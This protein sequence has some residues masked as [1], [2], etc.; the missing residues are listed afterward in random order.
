MYHRLASPTIAAPVLWLLSDGDRGQPEWPAGA[1]SAARAVDYAEANGL[2]AVVYR[3]LSAANVRVP[4]E[5]LRRLHAVHADD[6]S[7]ATTAEAWIRRVDSALVYAGVPAVWLKGAAWGNALYAQAGPRPMR[8]L[9]FIVSPGHVD[10]AIDVLGRLG[11]E[12]ER[13]ASPAPQHLPRFR[14][15]HDGIRI[16]LHHRLLPRRIYGF[17]VTEPPLDMVRHRRV[18]PDAS[19]DELLFHILHMYLH[20]F[21]HSFYNL[22][23]LHLHDIHLAGAKWEIEPNIVRTS[24]HR[25]MPP[26]LADCIQGLVL[27]LFG[28]SATGVPVSQRLVDHF[29]CNGSL[30]LWSIIPA[31]RNPAEAARVTVAET[32]RARFVLTKAPGR[33]GRPPAALHPPE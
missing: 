10:A 31:V 9:D 24:L 3:R 19:H 2:A 30:P 20:V 22:R 11:F 4:S 8:D 7:K 1:E 29:L 5:T 27:A 21:H 23:L 25:S 16:D 17:D 33:F 32:R 28:D 13:G 12:T 6:L 26:R 14:H 18:G 15:V